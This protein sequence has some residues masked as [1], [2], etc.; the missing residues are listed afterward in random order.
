MSASRDLIAAR[1]AKI[2]EENGGN[3]TPDAVL[4][5]ARSK[6]S[7]LHDQF[8]WNDG[9]AAH[10]YRLDQARTLIRSVR[11]EVVTEEKTV[12]VVRYLRNPEM[13]NK[14]QGYADVVVIR[15]STEL[16]RDALR[17]E[18]ARA[19]ALFDR[20]EALAVAFSMDA[21]IRELRQ[22]VIGMDERLRK[23]GDD[24]EDRVAA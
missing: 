19:R 1:L 15:D 8:E 22:R 4:E 7:P 9:E 16:A 18:F 13:P 14:A 21:E 24:D 3:L 20:A 17:T 2:A 6:K 5:D 23:P 11:V 10:K 12:S